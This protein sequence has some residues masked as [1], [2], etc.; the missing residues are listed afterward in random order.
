MFCKSSIAYAAIVLIVQIAG[1]VFLPEYNDM[2][3]FTF[4]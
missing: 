1:S 3:V 4:S 2:L